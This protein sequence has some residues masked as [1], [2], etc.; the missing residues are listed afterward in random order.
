MGDLQLVSADSHVN[1]PP[2]M[3]AD[4]LPKEYRDRAPVVEETG[5]G[6]FQVFEG[7]RTPILG[8]SA[9]AGK[10]PEDYSWNVRRLDEVRS[11]GW[12][13]DARLLDQDI[14]GVS[15]EVLYGGGPLR[16]QD[17]ALTR[18]SYSAYNDW[19]S[20]FCSTDSARLIGMAYLPIGDPDD[21]VAEVKRLAGK[22]TLR[23][24]VIGRFPASGDWFEERWDPL[25][26][27]LIDVGWPAA[28]HVGGTGRIVE[29]EAYCGDGDPA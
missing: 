27:T 26:E 16:S 21:T 10:R 2:T 22:Q 4:Y 24:G 7:Q 9:M 29:V 23:G 28:I 25:W 11:G 6:Q 12:D 3:W 14:D 8:I 18:A 19:L 1:P 5:E 13:P 20:D 15:A 17:P